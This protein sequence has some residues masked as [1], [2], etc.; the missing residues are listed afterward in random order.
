MH[1]LNLVLQP[2]NADM[3]YEA[4]S[5][6]PAGGLMADWTTTRTSPS[7]SSAPGWTWLATAPSLTLPPKA[8]PRCTYFSPLV[9]FQTVGSCLLKHHPLA[10][11]SVIGTPM[12]SICSG[13]CQ[14]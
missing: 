11:L 9:L 12:I 10:R 14:Y 2:L 6:V 1:A 3:N 13:S 5:N 4:R 7:A 8:S